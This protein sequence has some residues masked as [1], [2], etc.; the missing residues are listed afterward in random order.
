MRM[1]NTVVR[2]QLVRGKKL[3]N[4]REAGK[5]GGNLFSLLRVS[6]FILER[7][8]SRRSVPLLYLFLHFNSQN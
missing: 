4:R 5:E 7:R 8:R 6:L 3:L 1:G 2:S